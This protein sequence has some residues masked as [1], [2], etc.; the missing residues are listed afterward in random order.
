MGEPRIANAVMSRRW[1][2]EETLERDKG[3][4]QRRREEGIPEET[5]STCFTEQQDR[6]NRL[7][8]LTLEILRTE[9]RGHDEGTAST[10]EEKNEEQKD[11]DTRDE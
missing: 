5:R 1:Q 8:M 7:A 10:G 3:E 4:A 2:R 9:F 6:A 11:N